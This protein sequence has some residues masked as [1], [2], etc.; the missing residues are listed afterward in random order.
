M[1][2]ATAALTGVNS[3]P[4]PRNFHL[5]VAGQIVT[6]FGSALLRFA[7]SLYVLDITG[8]ADLFAALLALS[9]TPILLA[10]IGGAISDRFN[11]K[12]LMVLYDI[13]CCAVAFGFLLV[14][15]D[16]QASVFAVGSVMVILGVVGAMETPNG[17]AC[18]PQLVAKEKLGAA[19]GA[20]QAVQSLSG[21]A[22]PIVGG[23]LFGTLGLRFLVAISG[24]AFVLAA[25]MEMLI[26]IPFEKRD[27]AGGML[28]TISGDLRGGFNYVCKDSF[29]RKMMALAALLNLVLVPSFI[30]ATP[31]VFRVTLNSSDTLYGTGMGI[32]EFAMILGALLIGAF[33][34][35]MRV[36]TLWR[37]ILVISLL[38]VPLAFSVTPLILGLGHFPP[39]VLFL[40]CMSLMAAATTILSIF[41]ITKVQAKT[42]GENLGKV[43]AIIQAVAQC[44]APIGQIAYGFM[45]EQFEG[46]VYIPLLI[47][48]ILTLGIALFGKITLK[49]EDLSN[50]INYNNA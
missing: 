16:G 33:G 27:R 35:K 34:K 37:W 5:L 29:I 42:P 32:I 48:G 2:E 31:L 30:I 44:A 25:V 40:L 4:P 28:R 19:N 7:L 39:F 9:N 13:V 18:I 3:V 12:N 17:A 8:R 38:F 22:A 50:G 1:N 14:M 43:M 49:K 21:I 41:V 20:I 45:F 46:V 24:V 10:P 47:G 23:I 36:S 6:V 26:K 11:R 15:A